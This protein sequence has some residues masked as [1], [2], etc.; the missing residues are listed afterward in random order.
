M[1]VFMIND[2]SLIFLGTAVYHN[3]SM[4]RPDVSTT[5]TTPVYIL[6][7]SV[8]PFFFLHFSFFLLIKI[9]D[10][11]NMRSFRIFG[12]KKKMGNYEIIAGISMTFLKCGDRLSS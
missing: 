4:A 1:N 7:D 12:I 10:T 3:H 11:R 2:G 9:V 5:P 6:E 8:K